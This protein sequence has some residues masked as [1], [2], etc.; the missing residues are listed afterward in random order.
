MTHPILIWLGDKVVEGV[1]IFLV[2]GLLILIENKWGIMPRLTKFYHKFRNSKSPIILN[3]TYESNYDFNKIKEIVKK[4]FRKEY[5]KIDVYK[6]KN[7]LKFNVSQDFNFS[8]YDNKDN[9]IFQTTKLPTTMNSIEKEI[10]KILTV[11][12]KIEKKIKKEIE[13][14]T[15]IFKQKEFSVKLFLPYKSRYIK[16]YTPKNIEIKNYEIEFNDKEYSSVLKLKGDVFSIHS[17]EQMALEKVL[18][19]IIQSKVIYIKK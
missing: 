9:I 3:I 14:T 10:N 5:G 4:T 18:D 19:K 17:E 12:K 16:F 1:S 11:L 7:S 15:K 13:E 2:S 8:V 6:N